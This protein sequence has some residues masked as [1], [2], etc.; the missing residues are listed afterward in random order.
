MPRTVLDSARGRS[1]VT[2]GG[3]RIVRDVLSLLEPINE[4]DP[5]GVTDMY[6]ALQQASSGEATSLQVFNAADAHLG[7]AA[8]RPID[9]PAA[10]R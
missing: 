2:V 9:L 8:L 7:A 10:T 5:P 6:A 4:G 3:R 1:C